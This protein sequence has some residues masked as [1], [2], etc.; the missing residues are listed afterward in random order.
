MERSSHSCHGAWHRGAAGT[1]RLGHRAERLL[2]R[3]G[4]RRQVAFLGSGGARH[5]RLGG[6]RPRRRPPRRRRQPAAR[7]AGRDR[8]AARRR[9]D[10]ADGA[11]LG[12]GRP[13]GAA[14]LRG[15]GARRARPRA[16]SGS[17]R[18]RSRSARSS[19]ARTCRGRT[20]S[21]RWPRRSSACRSS[22]GSAV[23]F[24]LFGDHDVVDGAT[25]DRLP[26]VLFVGA[27]ISITAFPVLARIIEEHGLVGTPVGSLAVS[28]A[29]VND[30]LSWIA[31]ALALAADSSSS[32][33]EV[34]KLA[35]AAVGLVVVLAV[36]ARP[37]RPPPAP[38][39][40]G[41]AAV[42]ARDPRRRRRP[43]R[44]RARH[45]RDGPALRLRRVRLRRPLRPAVARAA[46]ADADPRRDVARPA[47]APAV[48]RPPGRDD[49]LPR[50]RPRQR[51]R[52]PASCSRSRPRRSS[53]PAASR[54]ARPGLSR[55]DALSVGVLLNTRGLVELVALG[56]GLS[57]GLLDSSLYAVLVIMAVVTTIA[58]SPSLRLLGFQDPVASPSG[59]WVLSLCDR[60]RS[61]V[62][63]EQRDALRRAAEVV[64]EFLG[65]DRNEALWDPPNVS[66]IDKTSPGP[67]GVGTTFHGLYAPRD[68]PTDIEILEYD[69]RGVS[70]AGRQQGDLDGH[71]SRPSALTAT[72]EP[73]SPRNGRCGRRASCAAR[74]V[75]QARLRQAARPARGA[76]REGH[77]QARP[78]D[79]CRYPRRPW[80]SRPS[81]TSSS[82]SSG[83]SSS[84][85]R[86]CRRT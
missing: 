1:R 44:R 63:A 33:V 72:V 77:S 23:A 41:A 52:D 57:A 21:R 25:V 32:G 2:S 51:R 55:H 34:A 20:T 19:S 48:P 35:G 86:R 42:V 49:E 79:D 62:R 50:P 78:R 28:C 46:R 69:R 40:R 85:T 12:A 9:R 36:L 29:A 30:V 5:A 75:D 24:G 31:L 65:D 58:T 66:K 39:R 3:P 80:R 64:F 15:H 13:L 11:R 68:Y 67:V 38:A 53:S 4:S 16:R 56:I 45:V 8:P 81:K 60:R 71:P 14:A 76:D 82:T 7:P 6:D 10:R 26:F 59:V 74:A 22:P 54:R 47:P 73:M 61:H 27:A 37:G 84:S 83:R 70:P 43:R 17:W 18:S